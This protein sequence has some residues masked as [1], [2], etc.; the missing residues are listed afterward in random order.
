MMSSPSTSRVTL[1]SQQLED[2]YYGGATNVRL[3]KSHIIHG[4]IK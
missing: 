3:V 1:I 4:T 2:T